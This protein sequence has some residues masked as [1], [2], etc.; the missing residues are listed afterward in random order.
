[1]RRQ[2]PFTGWLYADLLLALFV[3][4]LAA[5]TGA[6]VV[7]GHP[8]N[9]VSPSPSPSPT[10]SPTP[11]CTTS[12]ALKKYELKGVG[13]GAGNLPSDDELRNQFTRFSGQAAGLVLTFTHAKSATDGDVLSH[14]LNDRL[15]RLFPALFTSLTIMEDFSYTDPDA[16]HTGSVDFDVYLLQKCPA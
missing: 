7:S 14:Q 6:A 13:P 15:R 9:Q 12:V 11:T 5:T 16:S 8:R 1:V 2:G 3:V 4:F 10:P